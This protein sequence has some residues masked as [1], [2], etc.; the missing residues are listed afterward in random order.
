MQIKKIIT[1]LFVM[2]LLTG[3]VNK[4]EEPINTDEFAGMYIDPITEGN[5]VEELGNDIHKKLSNYFGEPKDSFNAENLS[6]F[7]KTVDIFDLTVLDVNGKQVDLSKYKNTKLLIEIAATYCSHCGDQ[8]KYLPAI[9]ECI[10]KDIDILQVF[11]DKNGDYENIVMFYAN[12]NQKMSDKEVII[13]YNFDLVD[14]LVSLGITQTPT[15]L[16]IDNGVIKTA[17]TSFNSKYLKQACDVGFTD[18]IHRDEIVNDKGEPIEKFYR[19]YHTVM[20][21]IKPEYKTVLD[22]L[23]DSNMYLIGNNAG[24]YF[25]WYDL[26][27]SYDDGYIKKESFSEYDGKDTIIFGLSND[28]GTELGKEINFINDFVDNNPSIKCLVIFLDDVEFY[29]FNTSNIYF[30]SDIT[31]KCGVASSR[32]SVPYLIDDIAYDFVYEGNVPMMLFVENNYITGMC[33]GTESFNNI[34]TLKD[35][36]F[37]DNCI[38]LAKN[39]NRNY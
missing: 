28:D 39:L 37:G 3:C 10:D 18:T 16:F 6:L 4:K 5:P 9:R 26:T 8:L 13:Q 12:N 7:G 17:L 38:T 36:F 23:H 32:S 24:Q 34:D 11:A 25:N 31:A 27:S 2:L 22:Q 1:F 15:F 35:M 29:N 14:R 30:H 20:K 33:V 21:E 19:T